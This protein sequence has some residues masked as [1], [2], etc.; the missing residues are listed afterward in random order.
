MSKVSSIISSY[1]VSVFNGQIEGVVSNILFNEKKTCKMANIKPKWWAV[2]GA[3][4]K[5]NL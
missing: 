3:R 4:H 1:V 5:Q 2:L